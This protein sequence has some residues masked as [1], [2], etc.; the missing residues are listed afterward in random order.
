M[1]AVAA[2]EQRDKGKKKP[3]AKTIILFNVKVFEEEEDLNELADKIFNEI[4]PEGLLW[5]KK[6]QII[7]IAYG[8]KML[9]ISMVVEDEK[10]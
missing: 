7:T 2:K 9:Q 10:I 1:E 3:I 6:Y 5:N 4:N 8:M